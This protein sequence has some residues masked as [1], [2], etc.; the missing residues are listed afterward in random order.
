MSGSRSVAVLVP[1]KAFGVAKLR[2]APSLAA[3]ER[4]DLARRMATTVIAAAHDLPVSVV[5][6]DTEVRT[7]AEDLGAAVIWSPGKGL[8]AAVTEAVG[9]LGDEGV[10][11]VIV[12]HADLPLARDLRWVADF[13][14]VTVVPDRRDDGTNVI[15]VPTRTGFR[16][17]YGPSSARRHVEEALRH[18][19]NVR[20]EHDADLAFDVDLPADVEELRATLGPTFVPS[21]AP[22]MT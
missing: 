16:F 15:A 1:V 11:Q 4:A 20:V 17:G 9:V 6:D 18:A 3:G 7:F 10:D 19:L 13:E 21:D 2:L 5:C 8:N 22:P 12:A 14:G